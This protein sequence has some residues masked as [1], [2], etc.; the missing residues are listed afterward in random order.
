MW[1]ACAQ[2]WRHVSCKAQPCCNCCAASCLLLTSPPSSTT[3]AAATIPPPLAA[4]TGC[5]HAQPP[6]RPHLALRPAWA[7]NAL[8]EKMLPPQLCSSSGRP[9]QHSPRH[10][11]YR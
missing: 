10:L 5:P 8:P 2:S 3:N 11:I 7:S 6:G 1:C 9:V 4:A